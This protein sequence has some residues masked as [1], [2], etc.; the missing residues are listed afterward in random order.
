MSDFEHCA[1]VIEEKLTAAKCMGT[2]ANI[3]INEEVARSIVNAFRAAEKIVVSAEQAEQMRR[4]QLSAQSALEKS[5]AIY[6]NMTIRMFI[7]IKL[8]RWAGSFSKKEVG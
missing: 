3:V 2:A 4:L 7:A 5:L 8:Y 6:E 1:Q